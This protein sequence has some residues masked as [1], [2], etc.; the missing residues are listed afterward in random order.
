MH[1]SFP[2]LIAHFFYRRRGASSKDRILSGSDIEI[3]ETQNGVFN[4]ILNAISAGDIGKITT[5]EGKP[6]YK[7]VGEIQTNR[8]H[9]ILNSLE[10][11]VKKKS[12]FKLT[13]L[14]LYT[15]LQFLDQSYVI[16]LDLK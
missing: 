10:Q 11:E 8:E 1:S 12:K 5:D 3:D 15:F 7:I 14:H 9:I 13:N 4:I 2:K 6:I 16:F